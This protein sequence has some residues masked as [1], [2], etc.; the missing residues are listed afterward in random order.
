MASRAE[1]AIK[2]GKE[3]PNAPVLEHNLEVKLPR[4]GHALIVGARRRQVVARKDGL[5]QVLARHA[6]EGELQ[7][8]VARLGCIFGQKNEALSGHE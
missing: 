6:P 8:L 5:V 2:E 1:T 3:D 4:K 7:G